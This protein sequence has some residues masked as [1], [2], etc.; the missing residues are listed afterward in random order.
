MTG[1]RKKHA[2]RA[3]WCSYCTWTQ[4][5][6]SYFLNILPLAEGPPIEWGR[7]SA[8]P[9]A[10]LE[11][12]PTA[13]VAHWPLSPGRPAS[14]HWKARVTLHVTLHESYPE[15]NSQCTS[16]LD[17]SI[18][19]EHWYT[20]MLSTGRLGRLSMGRLDFSLFLF[21]KLILGCQGNSTHPSV[22]TADVYECPSTSMTDI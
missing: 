17:L 3:T 6:A 16:F 5:G 10:L 20:I 22:E 12:S 11:A 7:V 9:C 2:L 19:Y 18:I 21:Q 1:A 15:D 14:I 8:G 4:G 13:A